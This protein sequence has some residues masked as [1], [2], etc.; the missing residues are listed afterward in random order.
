MS[1]IGE[2]YDYTYYWKYIYRQIILSQNLTE[3]YYYPSMSLNHLKMRLIRS[4]L[5][6]LTPEEGYKVNI[7]FKNIPYNI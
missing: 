7:N 3:K 4:G 6:N 5:T 2:K 1:I